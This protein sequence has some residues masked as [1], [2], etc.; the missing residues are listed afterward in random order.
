MNKRQSKK[1]LKMF[2]VR[3]VRQNFGYDMHLSRVRV[4]GSPGNQRVMIDLQR[5]PK[6]HYR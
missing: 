1:K 5:K 4:V 6:R 2:F 3:I